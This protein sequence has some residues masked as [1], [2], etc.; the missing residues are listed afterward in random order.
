MGRRGGRFRVEGGFSVGILLPETITFDQNF[1][2]VYQWYYEP[3]VDGWMLTLW[4][5]VR[6]KIFNGQ[7]EQMDL[8]PGYSLMLIANTTRH[9]IPTWYAIIDR[10]GPTYTGLTVEYDW[11]WVLVASYKCRWPFKSVDEQFVWIATYKG[12]MKEERPNWWPFTPFTPKG[13]QL[14]I[15]PPASPQILHHTQYEELGFS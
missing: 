5:S 12:E 9:H 4:P 6:V 14:K 15:S 2:F 7:R 8:G 11:P 10:V 1:S 13:D 3:K